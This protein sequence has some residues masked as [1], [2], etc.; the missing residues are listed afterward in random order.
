MKCDRCKIDT[1]EI[2]ETEEGVLCYGCDSKRLEEEDGYC[3]CKDCN[4]L[5][6]GVGIK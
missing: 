2:V 4:N 1:E 3:E 5:R 6:G